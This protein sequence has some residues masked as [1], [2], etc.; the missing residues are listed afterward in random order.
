MRFTGGWLHSEFIAQTSFRETPVFGNRLRT[1]GG[2]LIIIH[3]YCCHER[4]N[5][6]SSATWVEIFMSV[7]SLP[8]A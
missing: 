6:G 7:D 3:G 1:F 5:S 2:Q 8:S 4:C